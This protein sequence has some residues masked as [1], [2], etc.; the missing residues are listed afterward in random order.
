[1]A[2][3]WFSEVFSN[4][5]FP[6]FCTL[7]A[8]VDAFLFLS[9][10]LFANIYNQVSSYFPID[11]EYVITIFTGLTFLISFIIFLVKQKKTN[12]KV[13]NKS[14][15]K[16]VK[17][18]TVN[19]KMVYFI[20]DKKGNIVKINDDFYELFKNCSSKKNKWRQVINKVYIN[21]EEVN[22]KKLIQKINNNL[23]EFKIIFYLKNEH[24]IEVP[25]YRLPVVKN[26]KTVGYLYCNKKNS[27]TE[28][29]KTLA[30]NSAKK[31]LYTYF[32][33]IDLPLAYYDD[34][35][36]CYVCTNKMMEL[37]QLETSE[38]SVIDFQSYILSEDL[39]VFKTKMYAN[40]VNKYYYRMRTTSG[41]I[42]F[43]E[44]TLCVDEHEFQIVVHK[45]KNPNFTFK[46]YTYVEMINDIEKCYQN[47]KNFAIM[48]LSFKNIPSINSQSKVDN[49]DVLISKFFE[50]LSKQLQNKELKV[51]RFGDIEYG[52]LFENFE[53]YNFLVRSFNNNSSS[54]L[55]CDVYIGEVRY[56]LENKV[57]M[58]E[59]RSMP[60]ASAEQMIKAALDALDVASDSE[61]KNDYCIYYP[62]KTRKQV[63]NLLDYD[64]N[65]SDEYLDSIY[66]NEK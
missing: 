6:F 39:S 37:L 20:G 19:E 13:D 64:I 17:Y 16:D 33:L 15:S 41:Y 45:E 8:L 38:I 22:P 55:K 7:F 5:R 32:C 11:G 49:T 58:V 57:G 59:S 48:L 46:S 40:N 14:Q 50:K 66:K 65:L 42:W 54:I 4:K 51:Y 36:N 27:T 61:Y 10:K 60:S 47:G 34:A 56:S 30:F 24:K 23:D 25:I 35:K 29:A 52:I 31:K 63:Y 62:P 3:V 53:E 43:E 18:I 12:R 9:K 44:K 2:C 26:N 21:D 1:M 28:T